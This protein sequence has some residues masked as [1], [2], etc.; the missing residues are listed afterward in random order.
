MSKKAPSAAAPSITGASCHGKRISSSRVTA[1]GFLIVLPSNAAV[2]AAIQKP[3]SIPIIIESALPA[4]IP[5]KIT[6]KKW[7]PL[8]PEEMQTLV[9][10]SFVT[11]INSRVKTPRQAP[12]SSISQFGARSKTW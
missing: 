9:R 2:T 7:P 8:S 3:E 12:F 10:K 6:G 11:A 1:T 4:A 5:E